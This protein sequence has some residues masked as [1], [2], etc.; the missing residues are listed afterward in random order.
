MANG[1]TKA[2][3]CFSEGE[4]KVF[5][6]AVF[7]TLLII[8]AGRRRRRTVK[9]KLSRCHFFRRLAH[10][11]VRHLRYQICCRLGLAESGDVG[12]KAFP[13]MREVG[14]S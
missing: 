1:R 8:G 5:L 7:I 14:K 11:V 13:P 4:E 3:E 9:R 6:F 10:D 12:E 2:T